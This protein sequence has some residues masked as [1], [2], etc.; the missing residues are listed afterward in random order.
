M[1]QP[2]PAPR[3]TPEAYLILERAAATKSEYLDGEIFAMAGASRRHNL[4]TGNVLGELRA[5]LR[6]RPCEVY[7][8][9]MRVKIPA[10]GL[11]T[12]PDVVVACGEPRFEDAVLDTLLNP[13]LLVE[14][15]SESTAGYDRGAKFDHYRSIEALQEVLFVAQERI[16]V[17]HYVRQ[18]DGTWTLSEMQDPEGLLPLPSMEAE[19]LLAEVYAKVR[20]DD[21]AAPPGSPLK[22]F[23]GSGTR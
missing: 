8:S 6:H 4:I 1:A 2:D 10:T 14:V 16:H 13:T 19:L 15:L 23:R 22:S 11:Y 20:F 12:Y 21:P 5:Q 17:V 7:P 3:Y 18:D 9:D